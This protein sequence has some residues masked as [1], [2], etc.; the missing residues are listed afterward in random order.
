MYSNRGGGRG[1]KP[2]PPLDNELS[3]E[4]TPGSNETS[5]KTVASDW[6]DYCAS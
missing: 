3:N 1:V 2:V 6:D 4:N 5:E